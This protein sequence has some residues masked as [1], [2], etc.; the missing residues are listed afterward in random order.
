MKANFDPSYRAQN[1][2]SSEINPLNLKRD[3]KDKT[4]H[5]QK[6]FQTALNSPDQI[7]QGLLQDLSTS[8]LE[9]HKL[10]NMA[11]QIPKSDNDLLRIVKESGELLN[12]I[13]EAPI[14][15]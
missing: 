6:L 1:T 7:N 15:V 3:L 5:I 12:N 4:L 2:P 11:A 8:V 14:Y 10:C 13:L 9:L